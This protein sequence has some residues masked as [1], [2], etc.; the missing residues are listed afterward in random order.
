MIL[1]MVGA[2]FGGQ[3]HVYPSV[4]ITMP[5]NLK[6]ESGAAIG[7]KAILYALGQIEIGERATVSQYAHLCG[8]S[9]DYQSVHMDLLKTPIQIGSD[10]WVCADAFVGPGVRVGARA[11]LGARAV[12]TKSVPDDA[13][14]AGNPAIIIGTR[15]IENK[16]KSKNDAEN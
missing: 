1:R 13:I 15:R 14:V 5:W 10:A 7:D 2:Q 6:I 8:G 3:V 9:H 16:R 4:K 12:V 11:V